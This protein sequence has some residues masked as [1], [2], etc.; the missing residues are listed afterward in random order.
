MHSISDKK[1]LLVL[2]LQTLNFN[3]QY[4]FSLLINNMKALLKDL[5]RANLQQYCIYGKPNNTT[6][7]IL[8]CT[9]LDY[10]AVGS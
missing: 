8:Y 2:S 3:I 7:E 1:L 4:F 9:D 5:C 6:V 10:G